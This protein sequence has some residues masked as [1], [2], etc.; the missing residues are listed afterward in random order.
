MSRF[1]HPTTVLRVLEGIP[2]LAKQDAQDSNKIN[3]YET[4]WHRG[5]VPPS[6]KILCPFR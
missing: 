6:K 3:F 5:N 2:P 1:Y 4:S